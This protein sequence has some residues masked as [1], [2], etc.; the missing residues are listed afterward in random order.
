MRNDLFK[1]WPIEVFFGFSTREHGSLRLLGV[2]GDVAVRRSS[3]FSSLGVS[4]DAV[5]SA[6]LVHGAAVA[7]CTTKD[8]GRTLSDVDALITN[9][10]GVVLTVTVADCL[11]IFLAHTGKRTV[12]VA[13]AGWRGLRDN[14]VSAFVRAAQ[15]AANAPAAE[16]TAYIGPHVCVRHYPIGKEV[17]S[18]F[19]AYPEAV[20]TAP[21][22]LLDLA[23]VAQAQL[24]AAGLL[25]EQIFIS[26][27]CTFET[28]WLFSNRRDKPV[29]IEAQIAFISL[30]T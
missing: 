6:G 5:I 9:D 29:E 2:D 17:A 14:S 22:Q 23:V 8:A 1:E 12:G 27:V 16:F 11:P 15:V 26:T 25:P 7:I 4:P 21:G 30:P 28:P 13:H 24:L 18:A 3:F 20:L 19:A 10:S